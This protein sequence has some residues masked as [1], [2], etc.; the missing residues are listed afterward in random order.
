MYAPSP[1]YVDSCAYHEAGHTVV[2]VSLGMPLRN[3]GVHIDTIGNG[4][5][6]YWFRTVGDPNNTPADILERER[7]IV[8]T[9]AGFNAQKKFHPQCPPGGNWYDCDQNIKLLDE[10]YSANR[11]KWFPEQAKL[12]NESVRLVGQHWAAIDALANTILEQPLTPRV[13]DPER[14]WSTDTV[15]RW[16]D[17]KKI[18]SILLGFHLQP[19][20]RDESE[21]LFYPSVTPGAMIDPASDGGDEEKTI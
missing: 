15:E 2:A 19:V 4:I 14:P 5:S 17:G 18:V 3:G 12:N 21:G 10:M 1:I 16:I 9:Y 13:H 6:Y 8:S 11:D 20:I 7:T